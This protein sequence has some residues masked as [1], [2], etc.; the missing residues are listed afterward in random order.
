ML[1][2]L[3]LACASAPESDFEVERKAIAGRIRELVAGLEAAGRYDCCIQVPCNLCATR[4]G[5]CKCGEGLRRGEPVCEECALL[6]SQGQGAEPGVDPST[7]RSFLEAG[8]EK[9]AA[10]A[11]ACGHEGNP[12]P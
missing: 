10:A 4:V 6:W 8:R 12:P 5:G 11:C 7:V 9:T 1:V 3:L 2:L